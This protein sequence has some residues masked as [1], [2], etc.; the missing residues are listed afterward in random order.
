MEKL[1][2]R[3]S[4]DSV[5]RIDGELTHRYALL[6]GRRSTQSKKPLKGFQSNQPFKGSKPLK[7]L[8]FPI[9]FQFAFA[10]TIRKGANP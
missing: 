8:F 4:M 1:K 2:F 9:I 5:N 3:G 10:A 7:G 6:R